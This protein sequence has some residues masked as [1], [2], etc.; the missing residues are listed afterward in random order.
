MLH[1][2][3]DRHRTP[4]IAA[5]LLAAF[6]LLTACGGGGSGGTGSE[7]T[8]EEQIGLDGDGV[9]QRQAQAENLISECMRVR[10]FEY[11]PV[12]PVAQQQAL[13]GSRGLTKDE[14][15]AQYGYG[16]TTL[17]EQRQRLAELGP[18]RAIRDALSPADQTAYDRTLYG[19]DPTQTFAVAL[20]TGDFSRLGG[21]VKEAADMVFGGAQFLESLVAKLGE[22]DEQVKNDVRM[23]AAIEQWA[24]CMRQAGYG[25]A[26]PDEVDVVLR[27]QLEEIVGP[28]DARNADYDRAAL[29]ALQLEEVAMVTQDLACEDKHLAAVEE[30]VQAEYEREFRERNAGVLAKVPQ[31]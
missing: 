30:K 8:V 15:E 20:D 22:L 18:N 10:G 16:I 24:V 17:Y 14:F 23:V 28:P 25:L 7:V 2:A 27:T 31:P 4:T 6:G 19:D 11:V 9:L 29:D 13:T 21:C 26:D 1:R 3:H 12:D 5:A